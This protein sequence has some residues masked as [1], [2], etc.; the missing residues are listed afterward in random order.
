[1]DQK[2]VIVDDLKKRIENFNY[3]TKQ[4][5]VGTVLEIGD[6]IARIFGLND[7]AAMEMLE[8]S[9][10]VYGLALNLEADNVGAIILGDYKD[11]KEGDL[12]KSTGRLL[13]VPIGKELVGRVV[14]ALGQPIDNKG[15]I[16][17]K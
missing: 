2:N 3:E 15:P 14:N 8:F 11:I 17:T 16:K 6:G 7:V 13:Q 1:M 12:V 4:E 10:G 5:K 9:N